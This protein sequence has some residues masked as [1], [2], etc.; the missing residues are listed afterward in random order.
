[1]PWFIKTESFTKET[2]KLLPAQREEFIS[3]HKDWVV[4]LKKLGKAISSGYLVNENK[5]PGGGG[6]LIVEA[7]N[8]SAAKFL[9]EQDPMIVYGLV[10][11]EMHQWIPV[12]G[13]FPTD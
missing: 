3:K 6:L 9:I 5:I 8:F 2:L 4:N 12:I 10:N 13:E 1:M 11:W 7:E